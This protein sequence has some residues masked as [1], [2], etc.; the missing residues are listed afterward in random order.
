MS[1]ID[2]SKIKTTVIKGLVKEAL[3]NKVKVK[4]I[5][6]NFL[7][8][9][10]EYKNKRHYIFHK[11]VGLN[12]V[13]AAIVSNKYL[14]LKGLDKAGVKVPKAFLGSSYE[15]V[16]NLI[17]KKKIKYPFV[18]KPYDYSLGVAV[19]ANITSLN[20]IK[21]AI[22]R[23]NLYWRKAKKWGKKRR[24]KMF[25]IE[26]HAQGNDYRILVLNNKVIAGTQRAYPE[27]I[28]DGKNSV[29]KLVQKFYKTHPYYIKTKRE[30]LI[31][32]ELKRNLKIQNVNFKTILPKGQK[33]RLRQ[34]ANVFGGGIA[35]NVTNKIHPYYKKVA[36]LCASEFKMAIAGIDLMT[37]DISKKGDYRV[38]EINSFPSLDM[39]EHPQIG[40]PINISKII[41]KS[42][43]PELK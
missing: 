40:K 23:L 42:I 1:K 7:S 34:T 4:Q 9:V 13:N 30:P 39:H 6:P 41:L 15:E 36:L 14:T 28:G 20:D 22:S 43:F 24:K 10:L 38:I 11:K 37:K 29:W 16:K 35:I 31:D 19:T 2:Y 17:S 21:I 33:I 3:K 8:F 12:P 26:E 5:D 27:I 25:L 18:I 32:D